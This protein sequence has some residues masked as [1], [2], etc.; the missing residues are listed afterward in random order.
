VNDGSKMETISKILEAANGG[1]ATRTE[2]MYNVLSNY[3]QLTEY[4]RVL[5]QGDLRRYNGLT[6]ISKTA[7]MDLRFLSTYNWLNV[8]LKESQGIEE[9][10]D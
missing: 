8:W 2:R 6:Q 9:N 4:L 10:A 7:E 3:S 1:I 5:T